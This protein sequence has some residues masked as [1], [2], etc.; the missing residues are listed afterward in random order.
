M[1]VAHPLMLPQGSNLLLLTIQNRET[2]STTQVTSTGC[3]PFIRKSLQSLGFSESAT[4][5]ITYSW[6]TGTK[7]HYKTYLE[8][9]IQFCSKRKIDPVSPTVNTVIEFLTMLYE[10]G[11]QYSALNTARSAVSTVATLAAEVSVGKHPLVIRFMKGVFLLRFALPHYRETWNVGVVIKY[12]NNMA[13]T[14]E[15]TMENLTKKFTMLLALLSGQRTQTL[16]K[17]STNFMVLTSE[18]CCPYNS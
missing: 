3:L 4:N 10:D 8:R 9:W 6:R 17:L 14:P 16:A 1:L 13:P 11:L 5:I 12:L 2:A 15:L 7:K 18:K